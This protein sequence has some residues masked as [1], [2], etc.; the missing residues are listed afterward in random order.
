MKKFKLNILSL[1]LITALS[2]GVSYASVDI[3]Q[4]L[5][6]YEQAAQDLEKNKSKNTLE[7]LK[8][9]KPDDK[10]IQELMQQ[11]Q[12]L[13]QQVQKDGLAVSSV[14]GR[15]FDDVAVKTLKAEGEEKLKN[16]QQQEIS[17]IVDTYD[18]LIF[19][20]YGM[21]EQTL[22]QLYQINAGNKHVALVVRGLVKGTT[23]I[24][25]TIRILQKI[26]LDL[27]LEV[28]PNV[29][30]NPV[31][32]KQYHI[33]SVPTIVKLNA[34]TSKKSG[35]FDTGKEL[36]KVTELARVQ[37]IIDPAYLT[38]QI[39]LGKKGDLG[40][41]GPVVE[42]Q[43]RDM[44]EELQERAAK[45][46]WTQ[47]AE[48][49]KRRAWQ[50][51]PIEPLEHATTYRK[52]LVDPTVT[53][54]KDIIVD[55]PQH[56]GEKLVVARKGDRLNP[57]EYRPFDRLLVIFNPTIKAEVDYVQQ[58]LD[59]WIK[60]TQRTEQTTR[61]MITDLDRS[62][63]WDEY[64]GLIKK[65]DKPVYVLV[66]EVKKTF[67]LERTPA[68]VYAQQDALEFVVEEFNVD[69]KPEKLSKVNKDENKPK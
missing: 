28:P 26:A 3:N 39:T 1:S 49:A 55:D 64:N 20:S 58:H 53:I 40:V 10:K 16:L 25:D 19:I 22:K 44:I 13:V 51:I 46:N 30:I 69:E 7:S 60:Q 65:F 9:A 12:D 27:K 47:K 66:P 23:S 45:I 5:K 15:I 57:L 4:E 29:L 35:D 36:P 54:Q 38:E 14:G 67:V 48:N 33:T 62:G 43:E 50:N 6:F 11:N 61:L 41:K 34:N 42:I 68:I 31:W 63:G 17:K 32:F 52:R 24:E 59:G 18:T 21:D 8:I 37:G 2:V 56:K